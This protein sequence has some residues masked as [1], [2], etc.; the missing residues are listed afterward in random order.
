MKSVK[1][2]DL[3]AHLSAYLREVRDGGA[4]LVKDRETPF[5]VISPVAKEPEPLSIRKA[6]RPVSDLK[7]IKG[8]KP[9]KDFDVVED[10]LKDRRSRW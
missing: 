4:L 10:L 3:K 8:T 5:A 9:A 2:A 6:T 1:I 7:K